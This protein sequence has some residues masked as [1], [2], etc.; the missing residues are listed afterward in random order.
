M[1]AKPQEKPMH[2]VYLPFTEEELLEHFAPIT[3]SK[4]DPERHLTYYRRSLKR[5]NAYAGPAKVPKGE[6]RKALSAA[7][8]VEKDERFWVIAALLGAFRDE[9]GRVERLSQLLTLALCE[10][11]PITGFDRWEDCLA[12][13][14]HL[15]FEVSLPSPRAYRAWLR[16]NLD[17]RVLIPH[18]REAGQGSKLEGHTHVDAVLIAEDTGCAVV[19]EAKVLSD[20]DSKITYDA[21]R[22]QIARNI[23]VMLDSQTDHPRLGSVLKARKPQNTCFVLLTPEI[24]RS[25]PTSRLYGWLLPEYQNNSKR[26]G[27]DL[28]HRDDVSDWSAVSKRLG[29]LTFEECESVTQGTCRWLTVTEGAM[30]SPQGRLPRVTERASAD[31]LLGSERQ[32]TR[33]ATDGV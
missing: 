23:D 20:A 6:Q 33:V 25:N 18:L 3:G 1:E 12:G 22:N 13:P 32:S 4:A 8:Q 15:F 24:F 2:D 31:P 7:L 16:E 21:L 26:L 17:E 11:P 10:S 14:L 19:F 28:A 29:W 27:E 5:W 30:A 9:E